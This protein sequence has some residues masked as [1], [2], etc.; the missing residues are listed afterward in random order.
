M[1]HNESGP[2]TPE[3]QSLMRA[4]QRDWKT[5]E[6]LAQHP[7]A[8]PT[9][10]CFHAQQYVEKVIKAVL[11]SN[12]V[13]FRRTHDLEELAALLATQDIAP[14]LPMDQ[15]RQLNP[16]AVLLRYEEIEVVPIKVHAV[17]EMMD[18]VRMWGQ[19]HGMISPTVAD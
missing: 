5:V 10:L 3:A 6:L 18:T 15:L 12:D 8:P 4:A 13:I 1:P 14:P 7:D 19:E 16:F 9:S 2:I 11:V 17:V